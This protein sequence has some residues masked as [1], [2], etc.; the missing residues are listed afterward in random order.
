ML[1]R[2][3]KVRVLMLDVVCYP[4]WKLACKI[5]T[6]TM[7]SWERER[8]WKGIYQSIEEHKMV[9]KMK[10][11]QPLLVMG[12][13]DLQLRADRADAIA[14][15]VTNLIEQNQNL[16]EEVSEC[17]SLLSMIESNLSAGQN[18]DDVLAV[19]KTFLSKKSSRGVLI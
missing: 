17:L 3:Y 1:P 2:S 14:K 13:K 11:M 6:V 5:E 10:E 15:E 4:I 12:V 19:I 7:P 8:I 18:P 9:T 16:R